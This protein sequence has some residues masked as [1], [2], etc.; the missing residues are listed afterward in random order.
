MDSVNNSSEQSQ[1]QAKEYSVFDNLL[2]LIKQK[3][4]KHVDGIISSDA[5][6][7]MKKLQKHVLIE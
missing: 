2:L 3:L 7:A 5:Y 6:L 4:P 1:N